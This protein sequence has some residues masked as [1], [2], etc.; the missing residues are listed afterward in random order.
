MDRR[1]LMKATEHLEPYRTNWIL[2][3]YKYFELSK[4]TPKTMTPRVFT[5][6]NWDE[7]E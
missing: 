7:S 1:E 4:P 6:L 3:L 2:A 5:G